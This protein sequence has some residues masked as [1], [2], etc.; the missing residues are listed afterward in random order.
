MEGPLERIEKE[1]GTLSTL[2]KILLST[3]GSVTSLL[4]AIEG[5]EVMI[6]TLSQNVVPADAKTAEELEIRPGDQVNHRIVELRN[7][8]TRE[9]LI[10][11]VSDTPIERL[12][13]GFR[14]DLM[15]ADIPI[16]RIL[17]K[18]AIESRREIFHVGV[19]GSDARISRIFGIAL[20]D[21]VLFRK[22]RIIRQGKPFISIEEV[23]PD[24]SFRM[25]TGVLVSAPSRLHLGLIDLN[26]SLGR[27]DGG[28]GIAVQLPRT[29]ITAEQSP[30]LIVS[31]GTPPSARRAGDTAHRVLSSLGMCGGALIHIR[32]VP[33]GHVGL[34][35]G[36]ALSLAVARALCE[37]SGMPV[38]VRDL[39]MMTG[40]GGT[41]G[42]GTAA[43]ESGG[44]I[45]DGGHSYGPG[46]EKQEFLPSS[47]SPG[48]HPAPAVTRLNFPEEWEILIVIP[49]PE[50]TVSGAQETAIFRE[51][52]PVPLHEVR[53]IC[54]EVIMRLLPGVMEHDLDLFGAAVNRIQE[55]GFKRIERERQPLHLREL[56][57]CLRNA[58]AACAGMS[59]FG[60]AV[61]AVSGSGLD[62][63]EAAAR[64]LLGKKQAAFIRTRADNHGAIVRHL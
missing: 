30:D 18:H 16:G 26:G 2:Q 56:E 10:Y 37:L 5:E 39:A 44:L 14:S 40:R 21:Q 53:E 54:H 15:R 62:R 20:N 13:P 27:I 43:F 48:I 8:R 59:S 51:S 29:V 42:I 36:T 12:E 3:D 38:P 31:G 25:G 9:V 47:A 6:S 33:P 61:Y 17:K 7:S 1:H 57:S 28:I 35:L 22:Y 60:P 50:S 63:L 24:C 32:A 55:I 49:E 64:D 19:R 52:C 11:A 41:S 4:E 34:G 45:V 46:G 58:G 23:F